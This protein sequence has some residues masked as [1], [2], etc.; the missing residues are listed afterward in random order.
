MR[1]I[2]TLVVV[3]FLLGGG[4]ADLSGLKEPSIRWGVQ[5]PRGKGTFGPATMRPL[6]KLLW[7]FVR[8]YFCL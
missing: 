5:I 1:P 7:T 6:A 2:A 4:R 8:L 3:R